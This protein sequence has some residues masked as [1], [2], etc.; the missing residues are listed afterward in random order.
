MDFS[1][2]D[3]VIQLRERIEAFLDEHY[4]P[5]ELEA[6]QALDQ[7]VGPG[8]PYPDILVEIRER[9][10]REGLWNL[11]LPDEVYVEVTGEMQQTLDELSEERDLPLVG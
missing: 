11:F 3:R 1:P 5:V 6:L 9:A 7:E 2:S 8:K 10:K 4:Y